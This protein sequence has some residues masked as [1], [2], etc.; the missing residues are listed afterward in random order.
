MQKS[1]TLTPL[2][3]SST[4]TTDA[5]NTKK[6][7]RTTETTENTETENSKKPAK[8]LKTGITEVNRAEFINSITQATQFVDIGEF[9]IYSHNEIVAIKQNDDEQSIKHSYKNL[10]L[11]TTHCQTCIAICVYAK[12]THGKDVIAMLHWWNTARETGEE[13]LTFIEEN[14]EKR[15]VRLDTVKYH[16]IGGN[17]EPISKE[18]KES[19]L[20]A[21]NERNVSIRLQNINPG[22]MTNVFMDTRESYLTVENKTTFEQELLYSNIIYGRNPSEVIFSGDDDTRGILCAD[23]IAV[24]DDPQINRVRFCAQCSPDFCLTIFSRLWRRD[25][26]Q[27]IFNN[28]DIIPIQQSLGLLSLPAK[29]NSEYTK[30]TENF[31]IVEDGSTTLVLSNNRIHYSPLY[32]EKITYSAPQRNILYTSGVASCVALCVKALSSDDKPI[33]GMMHTDGALSADN[34]DQ[35]VS[36]ESDDVDDELTSEMD[37][38]TKA[39]ACIID[40]LNTNMQSAGAV[41]G[42]QYFLI[43][44]SCNDLYTTFAKVL[45]SRMETS[46]LCYHQH[47]HNITSGNIQ[48]EK[49]AEKSSIA[50]E[51]NTTSGYYALPKTQITILLEYDDCEEIA[52]KEIK[53]QI[54]PIYSAAGER[55]A[56]STTSTSTSTS[57]RTTV[58]THAAHAQT[59]A[60]KT[61]AAPLAPLT[62]I[63][64][65][66]LWP[67][68]V[69]PP[70]LPSESNQPQPQ[71]HGA[72]STI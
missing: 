30:G 27:I 51:F 26:T 28:P 39:A 36:D 16:L 4:S 41:K 35:S 18:D 20:T 11:Y 43:P 59:C 55:S 49:E 8:Q 46:Y 64:S 44:G 57:T 3:A 61:T 53:Y 32:R 24:K 37:Q 25:D 1:K 22:Y 2:T 60:M 23:Y 10:S 71:T 63:S 68:P 48:E 54:R 72:T 62:S 67:K 9:V 52:E 58:A 21:L 42:F 13:I 47:N 56:P 14:L 70:E 5:T 17:S 50:V 31:A 34:F 29:S 65:I 38:D 69:I 40:S 45:K 15:D 12:D 19:L 6:R 7:K 33:F 66:T